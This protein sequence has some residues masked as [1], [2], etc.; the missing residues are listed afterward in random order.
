MSLPSLP[1]AARLALF[2]LLATLAIGVTEAL[3]RGRVA[4]QAQAA[5]QSLLASVLPPG[6][7][8]SA[9]L[10][11]AMRWQDPELDPHGA[12]TLWRARQHGA[13]VAVAL[14]L[15]APDGYSGDIRL[16]LGLAADGHITGLRT[17][18]EHETP[19]LGDWIELDRSDWVLGFNGRGLGAP[20]LAGWNVRKDG[21]DFDQF[22]G[23]TI[24]PRAVVAAVRRALLAQ[25]R[26]WQ[27]WVTAPRAEA[28]P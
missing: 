25:Q 13:V 3:T 21:G 26:D 5:R 11:D 19:G 6:P 12:T 2:A 4:A 20:P 23:A 1:P 9:P 14:E 15:V 16:L 24:T 22:S 7:F 28:A 8:D 18:E 10:D 27:A 17:L